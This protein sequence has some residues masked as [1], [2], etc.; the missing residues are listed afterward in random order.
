LK[1]LIEKF[2][3]YLTAEK[4]CSPHTLRAYMGDLWHLADFMA[5]E[6]K[7]RPQEVDA[8]AIDN[9]CVRRY[10]A[11]LRQSGICKKSVA[12]KLST[13]R[14]FYHFL[15]RQHLLAEPKNFSV[16]TPKADKPLP[17]F[18]YYPEIEALL[19]AP[20]DSLAGLRDKAILELSYGAGLRVSELVAVNVGDIDNT[21]G[22]LRVLGKGCKE[23]IV[24]VGRPAMDAVRAYEQARC[25]DGKYPPQKGEALFLN[26]R[27]GRLTDRSVR[28]IVDKYIKIAAVNRHISPHTLR[29]TFATHLLENG[30][31]LRAVQEFLGHSSMSTTQ[32]YTHVTK[33]RLKEVY[34]KTHPRA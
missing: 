19:D 27:G 24:P 28:N 9:I 6:Q 8:A 18:L 32:I 14:S 7:C 31:D 3:V 5:K 17:K 12:R 25:G 20:D 30:A 11:H 26:L 29:H 2:S 22:Y 4:N 21:V 33:S 1:K 16:A 23:R 34:D 15:A 10:L 13:F